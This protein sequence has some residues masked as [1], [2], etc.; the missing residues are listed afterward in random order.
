M[1]EDSNGQI[2]KPKGPRLDLVSKVFPLV[3]GVNSVKRRCQVM[4]TN[5]K[6]LAWVSLLSVTV[7]GTAWAGSTGS[8]CE[9]AAWKTFLHDP[10]LNVVDNLGT[11]DEDLSAYGTPR[12]APQAAQSTTATGSK[13]SVNAVRVSPVA[14]D[15]AILHAYFQNA[16]L[17]PVDD[18]SDYGQDLSGSGRSAH[19]TVAQAHR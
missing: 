2:W 18:L 12:P 5:I 16:A 9:Q 14:I 3:R 17:H 4:N 1:A 10:T 13:R 15:E 7:A 19:T 6:S 11:Y 8:S